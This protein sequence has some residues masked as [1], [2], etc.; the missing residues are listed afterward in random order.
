[1]KDYIAKAMT[2]DGNITVYAAV[3][4]KTV[5]EAERIHRMNPTPCVA[6]GRTLIGAALISQTLK[7]EDHTVTIQIKGDGPI[8]GILAVS[9]SSAGVRGYVHNPSFDIPL[10]ESGKFDVG[11]AI[12][13][14]Y[15][16]L[17]KD[18]G[19]KEPYIGCVDLVSGEIAEDLAYYYAYSEQTPTAVNLGVLIGA[20]GKVLAAGGFFIQLLPMA[21]EDDAVYLEER[22]KAIPPITSLILEGYAPEAVI[23]ELLK[24]RDPKFVGTQEIRYRCTCSRE[25]ME[26]NL[27]SIGRDDL[28]EIAT[29]RRGAELH[30]HF[31]NTRYNF[32]PDQIDELIKNL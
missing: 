31:C 22:I 8:G 17:I 1:M 7:G 19:L 6:L 14:G 24:G 5:E 20:E 25:R 3:A 2:Q 11:R 13:K 29:D 32:T 10:N 9:D 27:L 28:M 4:T 16:N 30:C 12:G 23:A 26:R 18:I 21:S 15:L